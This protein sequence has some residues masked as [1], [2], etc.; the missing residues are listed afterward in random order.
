MSV[1][2]PTRAASKLVMTRLYWLY[3]Q[4]CFQR[5]FE[6]TQEALWRRG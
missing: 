1:H 3:F 5:S 4:P 6:K 2:R